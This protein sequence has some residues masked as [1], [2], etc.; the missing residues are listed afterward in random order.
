MFLA[1]VSPDDRP[2]LDLYH[3]ADVVERGNLAAGLVYA[4]F[5]LGTTFAFGG[6]LTGEGPGWWVVV[7]SFLLAYFEL[8]AIMALVSRL[9]GRSSSWRAPACSRGS[10]RA[11][12]R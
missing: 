4:G 6:A 5:V 7:V 9:S 10:T 2:I 3:P 11:T 12:R 8:R 1:Q